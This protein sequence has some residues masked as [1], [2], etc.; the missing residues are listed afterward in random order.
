MTLL[1]NQGSGSDGRKFEIHAS[2]YPISAS[3]SPVILAQFLALNA[4]VRYIRYQWVDLFGILR[5]RVLSSMYAL[6]LAATNGPVALPA[7][8]HAVLVDGSKM[9]DVDWAGKDRLYPDWMS[10]KKSNFGKDGDRYASV[11]CWVLESDVGN[12]ALGYQRCPRTTLQRALTHAKETCDLDFL[13]G[14]EV[15]FMLVGIS[16]NGDRYPLSEEGG[17]Y[18]ASGTRSAGFKYVEECV[19]A[20]SATGIGV[21]QFHSEGVAGQFEITT[22]PLPAM[23]AVDSLIATHEA[24]KNVLA[25][26]GHRAT[27][28]PKP[29]VDY[30]ANGAHTHISIHPADMEDHF[31]AGLL[32]RLRALCAFGLPVNESYVRVH[33]LE[34]GE[35]VEWGSENRTVPVRKINRGHWELRLAD[36][37][38]NMYLFLAASIAAG[39]LGVRRREELRWQDVSFLSADNTTTSEKGQPL[40]KNLKEALTH[41]AEESGSLEEILGDVIIRR[42]IQVKEHEEGKIGMLDAD[43][44]RQLYLQ[45]FS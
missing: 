23:Q 45:Q 22:A 21:L 4:N 5:V 9:P 17:L 18:T 28:Y 44:R 11:M 7:L 35:V 36:G 14:F 27:M 26:Y 12:P 43:E 16:P 2:D 31:L 6:Q 33:K 37:T 24:I 32:G 8:S 41:I 3:S 34:A 42:Y 29:F 38:A 10:L 15:E 13:V 40:P 19:E 25:K 20:I 30:P 39:T 1:Q